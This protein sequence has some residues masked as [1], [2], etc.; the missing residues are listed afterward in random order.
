MTV[1]IVVKCRDGIVIACDSLATSQRGVPVARYTNKVRIIEH[2]RLEFPIAVTGASSG[3][4]VD[5]FLNRAD[6]YMSAAPQ[7]WGQFDIDDFAERVCESVCSYL[8]KEYVIDRHQFFGVDVGNVYS[9]T[10][11]IAG[12]T[13]NR[14]LRAYFAH[15]I[16]LTEA[17]NDCGTIGSGSAYAELFLRQSIPDFANTTTEQTACLV[18]YAIKGVDLMDPFVGGKTNVSVLKMAEDELLIDEFPE[19]KMPKNAQQEM[20]EILERMTSDMRS[21]ADLPEGS[22]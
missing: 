13:S 20:E 17:I 10:L 5:K 19:E 8:L 16:G 6:D 11:I 14:D 7:K 22:E 15:S 2:D 1:G 21:L 4:F 9:L 18:T 12:A 3:A